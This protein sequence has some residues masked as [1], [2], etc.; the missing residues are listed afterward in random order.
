MLMTGLASGVAYSNS[1]MVSSIVTLPQRGAVVVDADIH[2]QRALEWAS[3]GE[4]AKAIVELRAYL[5][6]T[7]DLSILNDH[8]LE[9]I[10]TAG[11]YLE[12]KEE[13][14]YRP[15]P[16]AWLY[17]SMGVIGL[18]VSL[19]LL[20][21]RHRDRPAMITIALFVLFNSFFVFHLSLYV[22][23]AQYYLPHSLYLSTTFSFLYGPLL[24]FYFKRITQ[25]YEFRKIDLLH[26]LPSALLLIF[27]LPYYTMSGL[28]KFNVLLGRGSLL[29]PGADLI[30]LVKISSLVIYGYLVL[31]V[32]RKTT[33]N[34]EGIER[35]QWLWQR[36][37]LGIYG[38]Y[39]LA[40]IIYSGVIT[41][42]LPFEEL[43]HLQILVMVGLV[44]Y[45]AYLSYAQPDIFAG[46]VEMVD[47]GNLFKYRKSRLTTGYSV[48]L[49]DQLINLMD[50]EKIF[51]QN[52]LSLDTLAERLGTN[53]HNTS[54]V[55]NEHFGMNFFELINSY[56][57]QEAIAIFRSDRGKHMSIIEVAY[58]VGFNNKVTFNKSFKKHL[59]QTPTQFLTSLQG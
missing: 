5:E 48:E 20:F 42:L 33:M 28:E 57:I 25:G 23:N 53:R 35:R 59:S 40:Y 22:V 4:A 43:F 31:Q 38:L 8:L 41:G 39:T 51:M 24:Y 19:V 6:Q 1:N 52:D 7:G 14:T 3:Q 16:M 36:N 10:S 47:P 13:F 56:R 34:A 54:Q 58:E 18:F 17:L 21:R 11:A 55:I 49:K 37:I 30:I 9:P 2:K 29:L 26:L 12:F 45:V 27:L 50:V 46:A 44:A 32:L 15:N